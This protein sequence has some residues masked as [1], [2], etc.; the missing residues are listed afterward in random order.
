MEHVCDRCGKEN[1]EYSS[2]KVKVD[3]SEVKN[4]VKFNG[5]SY[6]KRV[7][8]RYVNALLNTEIE[9]EIKVCQKCQSEM[10]RR[11]DKKV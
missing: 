10:F 11:L 6:L 7:I 8:K 3:I 2:F 1:T 9:T 5:S 4:R